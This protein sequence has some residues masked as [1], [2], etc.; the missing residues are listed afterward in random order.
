MY[1]WKPGKNVRVD[2][3]KKITEFVSFDKPEGLR[4]GGN[5]PMAIRI[6]F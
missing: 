4:I 3:I 6:D 5:K 1:S 2:I